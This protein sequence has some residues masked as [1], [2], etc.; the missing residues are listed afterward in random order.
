MVAQMSPESWE[1]QM[2]KQKYNL[3]HVNNVELQCWGS[4][5]RFFIIKSF[6]EENI[7]KVNRFL[8]FSP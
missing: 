7:F 5:A 2:F 6:N 3:G 4:F 1:I 8:T